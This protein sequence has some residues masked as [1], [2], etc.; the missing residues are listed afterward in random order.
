[1]IGT[2]ALKRAVAGICLGWILLVCADTGFATTRLAKE[3]Q[4]ARA[5]AAAEDGQ[6]TSAIQPLSMDDLRAQS[7][8]PVFKSLQGAYSAIVLT[9][10]PN[11]PRVEEQMQVFRDNKDA[12]AGRAVAMIRFLHDDLDEIDELSRYNYRGWYRMNAEQQRFMERQLGTDNNVFSVVLVGRDGVLAQVWMPPEG[13]VPIGEIFSALDSQPR[14][15]AGALKT[16]ESK[17]DAG[18]R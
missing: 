17:T 1:M 12:L 15:G 16:P 11:E 18:R 6:K 10:E 8:P 13:I 14:A 2:S 5:A 4:Q 3:K 7:N 9:G